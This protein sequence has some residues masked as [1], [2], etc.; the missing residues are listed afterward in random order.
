M[1]TFG[2]E[3]DIGLITW[4]RTAE[5]WSD[6]EYA[7]YKVTLPA[8]GSEYD[9]WGTDIYTDDSPIGTAAVH[10]GLITFADGGTVKMQILPGYDSY[11]G[12]LRN[13][14]GSENFGAWGA[15]YKFVDADD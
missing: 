5:D 11:E 9:I 6:N 10:A 7:A 14:V 12:S 3:Q 13:G 15:S 2:E 1:D 8:G 4:D